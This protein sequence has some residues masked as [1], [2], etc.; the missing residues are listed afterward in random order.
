MSVEQ[1]MTRKVVTVELDTSLETIN[2]LFGLSRFHHLLV[3]DQ[4]SLVGIISDR[5]LFKALSPNLDQNLANQHDLATLKKRA[6]QIMSRKL[7][8]LPIDASLKRVAETFVERRVSCIPIV[9]ADMEVQGIVS[10]RDLLKYL[11]SLTH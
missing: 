4:G 3:V 9:N 8:T 2:K 10:W 11:L 1:I 5:D 6:H 7:V